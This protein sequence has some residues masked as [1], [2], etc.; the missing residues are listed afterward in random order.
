MRSVAWL[1]TLSVFLACADLA[2]AAL[3]FD[4]LVQQYSCTPDERQVEAH[5]AF[6][7]TGQTPVTIR[8]VKS[9]CG[10]T[11]TR[12]DKKVYAPG[13]KGEIVATFKFGFLRGAQ[14]KVVSVYTED[15]PEKAVLLD[16]R[17]FI[18]EP[19][20]VKPSLVHWKVGSDRVPKPVTLVSKGHPV[21]IKSVSSSNP[22]FTPVLE[23]IRD[24]EEYVV[25]IQPA[26]TNEKEA[27]Q[28]SIETDFP[29]NSPR[30]YTVHARVK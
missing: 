18:H 28:I 25:K 9:S 6:Q 22:R 26:D 1:L 21:R 7:N 3:S 30:T 17:V 10:C 8:R 4:K 14:R 5:F 27:A 2:E 23:T 24:G 20:E 13:E 11:T 12:L 29:A 16:L 15:E 19:F